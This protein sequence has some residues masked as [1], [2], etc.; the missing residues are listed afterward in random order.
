MGKGAQTLVTQHT[1]KRNQSIDT[2]KFILAVFVVIIHAEVDIGFLHPF[3]SAAIPIFF[4][5][6]SYFFFGKIN[7][8]K[9]RDEQMSHLWKFLKRNMMLYGFWFLVL[10]PITLYIRDWFSGSVVTAILRFLQAFFFNSTFRG[11]WYI[12][13]LNIG[14]LLVFFASAKIRTPVLLMMALPVYLIAC[15]F[16]NYYGLVADNG[17]IMGLYNGYMHIFRSL[18]NSFP[19]GIFWIVLGK[20][21]AEGETRLKQ[22]SLLIVILVSSV[23]LVLEHGVIARYGLALS[24]HGYLML[25]PLCWA[26]FCWVKNTNVSVGANLRL[27]HMSTIIYAV[28]TSLVSVLGA[29]LRRATPLTGDLLQWTLLF[30]TMGCSLIVCGMIF[31]LERKKGLRWL[32]YAY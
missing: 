9:S 26:V 22:S 30:V 6:S 12:M 21:L 7:K 32:R 2:M 24:N 5:T 19:A 14:V 25:V 13:A 16:S 20:M 8:A 10:L 11:S 23:L 4:I 17:A 29:I 3:L 1:S 15:L 27:G 28:H 31:A 18:N